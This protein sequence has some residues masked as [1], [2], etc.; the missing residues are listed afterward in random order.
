MRK[1]GRDCTQ[2]HRANACF[3]EWENYSHV[4][5]QTKMIMHFSLTFK[6]RLRS[7]RL[8]HANITLFGTIDPFNA[9]KQS[10]S[11]SDCGHC[12]PTRIIISDKNIYSN[13]KF[14][15]FSISITTERTNT[16]KNWQTKHCNAQR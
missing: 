3:T 15:N 10:L 4:R 6:A 12:R 13:V 7:Q 2:V 5:L 1:L 9:S 8:L 16:K 11:S 14:T